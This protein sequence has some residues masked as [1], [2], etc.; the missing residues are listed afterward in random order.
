M[1]RTAKKSGTRPVKIHRD[2]VIQVIQQDPSRWREVVSDPRV[3]SAEEAI[4]ALR[5]GPEYLESGGGE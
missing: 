3:S 5:D 2:L 4:Q 1:E